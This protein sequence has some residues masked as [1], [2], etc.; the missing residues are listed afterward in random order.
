MAINKTIFTADRTTQKS[1]ILSWLQANATDYF[2]EIAEDSGNIKCSL[3]NGAELLFMFDTSAT[4]YKVMS[5]TEKS[6]YIYSGSAESAY[7]KAG[8]ATS[9]GLM[10][11]STAASST[12]NIIIISKTN[13]GTTAISAFAKTSSGSASLPFHY[14]I[15]LNNDTDWIGTTQNILTYSVSVT[16][17]A[18]VCFSSGNY[19]EHVFMTIFSQFTNNPCIMQINGKK[20]AYGGY[21]ALEE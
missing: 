18:P 6:K 1:E 4:I 8:I 16:S 17:L 10:L 12:D 15:D 9:K 19:C 13:S 3:E 21:L 14:F 7:T 2:D 5:K 11:I 20:Y